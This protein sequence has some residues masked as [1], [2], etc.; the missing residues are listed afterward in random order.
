MIDVKT[1]FRI[2]FKFSPNQLQ[3][4]WKIIVRPTLRVT[5]RKLVELSPTSRSIL[6][7]SQSKKINVISQARTLTSQV[8]T[9]IAPLV[10]GSS[11]AL[12][13]FGSYGWEYCV[14]ESA[15][16]SN[17]KFVSRP[18]IFDFYFFPLFYF[19]FYFDY[20][21]FFCITTFN[22]ISLLFCTLT[23]DKSA[24]ITFK[25]RGIFGRI[26]TIS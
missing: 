4:Q 3:F 23:N 7:L 11:F 8:N 18:K 26:C 25:C 13:L 21:F 6:N 15:Y 14:N 16:A 9:D 1:F 24:L 19:C 10:R 5:V 17:A 12:S 2:Y 20:W 22:N